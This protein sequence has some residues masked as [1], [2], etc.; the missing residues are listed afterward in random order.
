MIGQSY[1][2]VSGVIEE[3]LIGLYRLGTTNLHKINVKEYQGDYQGYFYYRKN[4][5]PEKYERLFFDEN[6][7]EPYSEDLESIIID[8][9]LNGFLDLEK[10]I[11]IK[12]VEKYLSEQ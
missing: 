9:V 4:K 7:H 1:Q 5:H 6:G 12:E 2:E 11:Q 3:D 10:N 8:F